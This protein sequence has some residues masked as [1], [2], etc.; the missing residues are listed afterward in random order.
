[1]E[2]L[3]DST[4][5]GMSYEN[6]KHENE[7]PGSS[8]GSMMTIHSL[9]TELWSHQ[10]GS[11]ANNSTRTRWWYPAAIQMS[12]IMEKQTH[13][14][15]ATD[16]DGFIGR[17]PRPIGPAPA[18]TQPGPTP[19]GARFAQ[20]SHRQPQQQRRFS[21]FS[22][23]PAPPN[24]PPPFLSHCWRHQRPIGCRSVDPI[25]NCSI[26]LTFASDAKPIQLNHLRNNSVTLRKFFSDWIG[27]L[28]SWWH[29]KLTESKSESNCRSKQV[30]Q[31]GILWRIC[32]FRLVTTCLNQWDPHGAD[33]IS[34][35]SAVTL[36]TK[37]VRSREIQWKP[38][39]LNK[40]Q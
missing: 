34:S 27:S 23:P 9:H 4:H 18:S 16:S 19:I 8:V 11:S 39:E 32:F 22:A 7:R 14:R 6:T 15:V 37:C 1:M 31:S 12:S 3:R 24:P 30:C 2:I 28:Q 35:Q 26:C 10:I 33:A 17:L 29:K 13:N 36:G 40:M 21:L 38:F 5:T 25:L 20:K